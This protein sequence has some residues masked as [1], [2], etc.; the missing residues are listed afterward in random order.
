MCVGEQIGYALVW[1]VWLFSDCKINS[2]SL[3][4]LCAVKNKLITNKLTAL[5]GCWSKG[6]RHAA[7]ITSSPATMRRNG[8]ISH[9]L[10]LSTPDY[11]SCSGAR[12]A[13]GCNPLD[14]N[15]EEAWV[16]KRVQSGTPLLLI[17]QLDITCSGAV[18]AIKLD[19]TEGLSTDCM[20][21]EMK[22]A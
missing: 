18:T 16:G 6:E 1:L 12:K 21:G 11:C 7:K 3:L 14:P 22:L 10:C 17:S 4:P 8:H 20:G 9:A 19:H 13:V 15:E 2:S 5:G